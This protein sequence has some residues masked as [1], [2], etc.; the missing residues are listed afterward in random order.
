MLVSG[1]SDLFPRLGI[2][3]LFLL[4]V[5]QGLNA[6]FSAAC[7]AGKDSIPHRF[8]GQDALAPMEDAICARLSWCL[9][10]FVTLSE[11]RTHLAMAHTA[12]VPL[13]SCQSR[14]WHSLHSFDGCMEIVGGGGGGAAILGFGGLLYRSRFRGCLR[15]CMRTR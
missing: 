1:L 11:V 10:G 4:L 5:D 14:C 8:G 6:S 12:G 15:G 7:D 2:R 3:D 13:T 9:K